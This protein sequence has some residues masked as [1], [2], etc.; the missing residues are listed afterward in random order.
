MSTSPPARPW[1]LDRLQLDAGASHRAIRSAY[2][3]ELKLIDQDTDLDAFQELRDA[4]EAALAELTTLPPGPAPSDGSASPF[5]AAVADGK[6]AFARFQTAIADHLAAPMPERLDMLKGALKHTLR[7]DTLINFDARDTFEAQLV[8]LLVR[9]WKTG[10]ETLFDAAS[11]TL[12]WDEHQDF[13]VGLGN[14]G[15][16]I[17]L[18]MEERARLAYERDLDVRR[19]HRIMTR[20]RLGRD[21]DPQLLPLE[22]PHLHKLKTRFPHY[23]A[24]AADQDAVVRWFKSYKSIGGTFAPVPGVPSE[25]IYTPAGQPAAGPASMRAGLYAIGHLIF[26]LICMIVVIGR[27]F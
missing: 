27:F 12:R 17:L 3:R 13:L 7:E 24:I 8:A 2:A 1:F 5:Q 14:D 15:V 26:F 9:G 19:Y 11:H 22:M 10:H 16:T 18:A 21:P 20:L 6:A 4:Y 23:L 25:S